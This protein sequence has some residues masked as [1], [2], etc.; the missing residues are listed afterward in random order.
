MTLSGQAGVL[1]FHRHT[2]GE[3]TTTPTRSQLRSVWI[4]LGP[5]YFWIVCSYQE[6]FETDIEQSYTWVMSKQG[7][8]IP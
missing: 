7:R 3:V 4:Y 5:W 6:I 8:F 1:S 2:T